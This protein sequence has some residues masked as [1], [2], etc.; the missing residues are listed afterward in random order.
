MKEEWFLSTSRALRENLSYFDLKI[1]WTVV[2]H[3]CGVFFRTSSYVSRGRSWG[4]THLK[5]MK[6]LYFVCLGRTIL[7]IWGEI[8]MALKK[9]YYTVFEN[10]IPV[11][12]ETN[13]EIF[14]GKVLDFQSSQYFDQIFFGFRE[15]NLRPGLSKFHSASPDEGFE[16]FVFEKTMIFFNLCTLSGKVSHFCKTITARF[17]KHQSKC[18]GKLFAKFFFS[19]LMVSYYFRFSSEKQR[20]LAKNLRRGFRNH[21]LHVQGNN[22]RNFF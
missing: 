6:F 3:F 14:L 21:N 2:K 12:W 13:W 7:V 5:L 8:F 19:K 9:N 16:D 18:P 4:R 10:A 11:S 22:L 17:P 15:K 20:K 1:S